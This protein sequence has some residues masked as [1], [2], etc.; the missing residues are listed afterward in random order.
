M[1]KIEL[2]KIEKQAHNWRKISKKIYKY[3]L[4]LNC[5]APSPK[6]VCSRPNSWY[7]GMWADLELGLLQMIRFRRGTER[8]CEDMGRRPHE[9]R[10]LGRCTHNAKESQRAW[11]HLERAWKDS[12]LERV[13]KDS[14][15]EASEEQARRIPMFKRIIQRK[16]MTE[17]WGT[18]NKKTHWSS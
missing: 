2:N 14:H 13:W 5:C 8:W 10:G 3:G 1:I 11:S 15:L 12:R 17:K 9:D 18:S 16:L 4:A 6:Q 7:L